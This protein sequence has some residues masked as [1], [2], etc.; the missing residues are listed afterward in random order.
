M[1]SIS[2]RLPRH[3][4]CAAVLPGGGVRDGGAA[5]TLRGDRAYQRDLLKYSSTGFALPFPDCRLF[6]EVRRECSGAKSPQT[7]QS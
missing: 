2:A 4:L 7:I 3:R 5:R 6:S 1:V